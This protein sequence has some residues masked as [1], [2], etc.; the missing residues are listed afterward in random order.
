MS[1]TFP[2]QREFAD[3]AELVPAFAAWT[4]DLLRAA[5][6]ARGAALLIVSGGILLHTWSADCC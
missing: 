2:E 4:A 6:E 1:A 3:G 5:I